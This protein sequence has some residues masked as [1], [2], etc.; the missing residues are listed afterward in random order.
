[1][2]AT[3]G[4]G[5]WDDPSSIPPELE[6]TGS[7]GL[8]ATGTTID[9]AIQ[10][11]AVVN[12]FTTVAAGTGAKLNAQLPIQ[13]VRNGGANALK[14]YPANADGVLNGGSPG[15]EVSVAAGA[16]AVFAQSAYNTSIA[17]EAAAA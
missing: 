8:T 5:L 16:L 10:M 11:H 15:A 4:K 6:T 13:Y 9:D 7:S 14:V 3:L 17:F 1:M 12:E 2:N